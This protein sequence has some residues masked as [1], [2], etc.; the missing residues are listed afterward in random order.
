MTIL[1]FPA[2]SGLTWPVKKSPSFQTLKHKSVAGTSTMQSLQPYAIYA[3]ELPFELSPA[4]GETD[5]K[6]LTLS[7]RD[8]TISV[9]SLDAHRKIP[10]NSLSSG[11]KQM[12]SLFAKLYLYPRDKI[13]LIDEPELSLSID[14][15]RQILVDIVQAP[16]CRQVVA[17]TH[18]PFVFD[19]TLE[20]FARPLTSTIDADRASQVPDDFETDNQ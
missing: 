10:L 3:F 15:Q 20:P 16:L 12:I 19:N 9:E 7:R 8:L 5:G 11:E 1:T 6:A 18:S 14:W 13:I 4:N 17:I 2:L